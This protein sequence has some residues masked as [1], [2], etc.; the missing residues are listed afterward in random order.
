MSDTE[1][2]RPAVGRR[3]AG[4][5][6]VAL[7]CVLF[8]ISSG[9]P[10]ASAASTQTITSSGPLTSIGIS[11]TLNCSVNHTGDASGE[12]FGDT[13][14]GTF[15]AAGGNIY[16]PPSVPAGGNV[17]GASNFVAFTPVSQSAVTGAGTVADPYKIVTVVDAGTTGLRVTET[18]T[19]VVGQETYRSD[20][21]V[22]SSGAQAAAVVYR[23]GD[24]FLQDSDT[25]FGAVDATTGS[26]SCVGVTTVN[27]TDVPSSRIE[28]WRPLT[29]GSSH[30]EAS[31]S[32][33]WSAIATGSPF[34]NTC[35][36][37]ENIDNGAGL[38]WSI[39]VPA[40]GAVTLSHLTSFSPAGNQPLTTTKTADAGSVA[41]G[42]ADGYTITVANPNTSAVTLNSVVD[43][44]PAGFAYTPGSTTGLTTANPSVNGQ[45]L[46]WAGPLTV[47]ANGSASL[48]F[49]V[50]ASST[51]GTYYNNAGADG[52]TF[53]VVATGDTAPITVTAATTTSSSSTTSTSTPG[54][55]TT[56]STPGSTTSTS[57][58]ST[59]STSTSLPGT[60]STSVAT[61]ST[62]STSTS[63]TVVGATTTSTSATSTT[64][65]TTTTV[66][67]STTTT[68]TTVAPTSTT[69]A[70]TTTTRPTTTVGPS[71][72]TTVPGVT[73]TANVTRP[74]VVA[75]EQTTVFGSGFPALTVLNLELHSDPVALG[76]TQ[77]DAAGRYSLVVTIPAGTAPGVH[78]IVVSGGGAQATT[79]VTVVLPAG[80][81]LART[82]SAPRGV[83]RVAAVALAGGGLLLL[84]D[85]GEPVADVAGR[86]AWPRRR[87]F[88]RRSW[89]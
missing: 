55:T 24:C 23:A 81:V 7:A 88:G 34:D 9:A 68:A 87:R 2:G 63:T 20:V 83:L 13:A 32:Q 21:T 62:T 65:S 77:T 52:G 33:V 15:L 35:R 4:A 46:T 60:T 47:P 16:G 48:H 50:T 37:N 6:C 67:A 66:A 84:L 57:S 10:S 29:G 49:G 42:A 85:R 28:Q 56:T 14:C 58:T 39:T 8:V 43:T 22:A 1:R 44:L 41:A 11:D 40:G 3:R 75:G 19:Y 54:S 61:S 74:V 30:Y 78:Q 82:G 36:C 79:S 25:G 31:Y 38:S 70:T 86:R 64:S 80:K 18:D 59:S 26:V 51:P 12:F 73:P 72:T 17:T 89:F 45:V 71:T 76:S 53:A 27:G 5:A 69:A